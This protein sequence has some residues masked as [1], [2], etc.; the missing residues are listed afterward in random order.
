MSSLPCRDASV[1]DDI[2]TIQIIGGY[3]YGGL[4]I[5]FVLFIFTAA[6]ITE[7]IKPR[8][9][10]KPPL[11]TNNQCCSCMDKLKEIGHEMMRLRAIYFVIVVHI[12]DTLTDFLIMLEWYIKGDS[13]RRHKIAC[14][15]INYLGCFYFSVL[16]LLFYR[17]LSAHFIYKYYQKSPLKAIISSIGQLLDITIFYEVYQSHIHASQTD[18]LSYLSKLE[19]TFESSLQ[20][21]LQMYVLMRVVSLSSQEEI[22][23]SYISIL[24]ILFSLV[25]LSTKVI[26]DDQLAFTREASKKHKHP[27]YFRSM[28]RLC[29]I[30]HRL[31]AITLFATFFGANFLIIILFMDGLTNVLLFDHGLLDNDPLNVMSYLLCTMNLGLIPKS[32]HQLISKSFMDRHPLFETFWHSLLIFMTRLQMITLCK[33]TTKNDHY[34][35]YYLMRSKC[36]QSFFILL[37]VTTFALID[38]NSS[39]HFDCFVCTDGDDRKPLYDSYHFL[40]FLTVGYVCC[41]LTYVTY[42]FSNVFY[43]KTGIILDRSPWVL[44][45]NFKFFDSIRA[46]KAHV[47]GRHAFKIQLTLQ[48][49][50]DVNARLPTLTVPTLPRRH[51]YNADDI[52]DKYPQLSYLMKEINDNLPRHILYELL[53]NAIL[54]LHDNFVDFFLN[55]YIAQNISHYD[56][57]AYTNA[58]NQ[59]LLQLAI[60]GQNNKMIKTVYLNCPK[61]LKHHEYRMFYELWRSKYSA[62]IDCIIHKDYDFDL[63]REPNP[64]SGKSILF[65]CVD[66]KLYSILLLLLRRLDK[67]NFDEIK[68]K[69][70]NVLF[71]AIKMNDTFVVDAVRA[72]IAMDWN[73]LI[74]DYHDHE[75]SQI[76]HVN[77]VGYAVINGNASTLRHML[78]YESNLSMITKEI[79]CTLRFEDESDDKEMYFTPLFIAISLHQKSLEIM[80]ILLFHGADPKHVPYYADTLADKGHDWIRDLT[81][82]QKD[83]Q[84][85][86]ALLNTAVVDQEVQRINSLE[87]LEMSVIR[88]TQK[89]YVYTSDESM[90]M[91]LYVD[92]IIQTDNTKIFQLLMNHFTLDPFRWKSDNDTVIGLCTRYDSVHIL[93][94]LV[95]L[96]ISHW[97]MDVDKQKDSVRNSPFF[98][99]SATGKRIPSIK[100]VEACELLLQLGFSIPLPGHNYKTS[101]LYSMCT[102]GSTLQGADIVAWLLKN[103]VRLTDASEEYDEEH[104]DQNSDSKYCASAA[105]ADACNY[106]VD[107]YKCLPV[108]MPLCDL[109]RR[110]HDSEDSLLHLAVRRCHIT[111]VRILLANGFDID[112]T[113]ANGQTPLHQLCGPPPKDMTQ[114]PARVNKMVYMLIHAFDAD[115]HV[116]DAEGNTALH[117]AMKQ[118]WHERVKILID[119]KANANAQ[120]KRMETPLHIACNQ[121][122]GNVPYRTHLIHKLLFVWNAKVDLTKKD[123]NGDTVVHIA[124]QYGYES[125]TNKYDVRRL[126]LLAKAGADMNEPNAAG[127]SPLKIAFLRGRNTAFKALLAAECNTNGVLEWVVEREEAFDDKNVIQRKRKKKAYLGYFEDLLID[128]ADFENKAEYLQKLET[129]RSYQEMYIKYKA[130]MPQM[131]YDEKKAKMEQRPGDYKAFELNA[132]ELKDHLKDD[133]HD[134]LEDEKDET[135]DKQRLIKDY[136][137]K[138]DVT[139][140]VRKDD[141]KI[142]EI[143]DVY[144]A[145]MDNNDES[146]FASLY[147][148]QIIMSYVWDDEWLLLNN[149][150]SANQYEPILLNCFA[151]KQFKLKIDDII[152]KIRRDCNKNQSNLMVEALTFAYGVS[153]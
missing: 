7:C 129:L 104:K 94:Q 46:Y 130:S 50:I 51:M 144:L 60:L 16:I 28:F 97:T 121:E 23:I 6:L 39:W 122:D 31:L 66:R 14:N 117:V 126:K 81:F 30:G 113:N 141:K 67:D 137:K 151:H 133:V 25:A 38:S 127:Q 106:R 37:I 9:P 2:S 112:I 65:T 118:I 58:N 103:G 69:T 148:N 4:Y 73:D 1:S 88:K 78:I 72:H 79:R 24:S 105:L 90:N 123:M 53:E 82:N 29:E 13:E 62:T 22:D 44:F 8:Q 102:T 47:Y 70:F 12:F 57:I 19:K 86:K 77:P 63:I 89:N 128:G 43:M 96:V 92:K 49:I 11:T 140:K 101:L 119:A 93:Q 109:N 20:L 111:T 48:R 56:P 138:T 116:A 3:V 134:P 36:I 142:N 75:S 132:D 45:V 149:I 120:N 32:K 110:F 52:T 99:M 98:E 85:I 125:R 42:S 71:Y 26:A 124:V 59:N 114:P 145:M 74:F 131:L 68:Y 91:H 95:P 5:G 76:Y 18:N 84:N 136:R 150:C 147:F 35:S 107:L 135:D 40:T 55:D 10:N 87:F 83:T 64:L 17:T 139:I 152:C 61:L 153:Y 21:V 15:G 100:S 54:S 33:I 41:I 34:L 146:E 108:L 27:F 80:K 143:L 115:V